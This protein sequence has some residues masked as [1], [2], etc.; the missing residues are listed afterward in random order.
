MS[1]IAIMGV[2]GYSGTHI[3]AE[4]LARGHDVIG[5]SRNAPAEPAADVDYRVG[6]ADDRALLAELFAE[7][8]VVVSAV[9]GSAD[10]KPFLAGLVPD[11]LELAAENGTRLG[12]VGGASS[13]QA[14]PGGP[15]LID[16]LGLKNDAEAS[17]QAEV[18]DALRG[19]DTSADW[20]YVSP[21][22]TYGAQAPGKRTGSYRT[23]DDVLLK[24]PAGKSEIGGDDFAIA[25]LD[26]IERPAHHKARFTVAY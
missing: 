12:I 5:V 19:A 15:R 4:A 6:S 9:H 14:V 13:L 23:G 22:A 2:T 24:N 16:A 11:M 10:G 3:A 25:F 8:D 26:E 18:L 20:F 21:P 17:S 1:K 7:A